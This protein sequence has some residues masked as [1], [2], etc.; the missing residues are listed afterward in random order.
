MTD[1]YIL[2]PDKSLPGFLAKNTLTAE[3]V[4]GLCLPTILADNLDKS[5]FVRDIFGSYHFSGQLHNEKDV[6]RALQV[7][8]EKP[9]YAEIVA[10]EWDKIVSLFEEVFQHTKFTGRSGTFFGYEG[11]GSVY[12]HMVSKLLLATQETAWQHQH[13]P[14]MRGLVGQGN[15]I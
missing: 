9:Q 1:Y 4:N 7:L 6:N 11:L 2:Y 5:L 14:A 10:V 12:W 15:C 8:A 13:E 3:Q